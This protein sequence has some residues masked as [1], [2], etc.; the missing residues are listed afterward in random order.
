MSTYRVL[1][2]HGEVVG[3]KDIA[4]ADDAH[5]WFVDVKADNTELGWRMEVDLDGQWRFFDS[6]EGDRP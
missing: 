6:T 5:A 1:N 2:P 3:T 4:S